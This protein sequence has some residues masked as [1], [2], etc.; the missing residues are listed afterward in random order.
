MEK[1][2]QPWDQVNVLVCFFFGF[3]FGCFIFLFFYFLFFFGGGGCSR[4]AEE[5]RTDCFTSIVVLPL[6]G[7]Q[8]SVSQPRG[9]VDW[10][11]VYDCVA[12]PDHTYIVLMCL[13]H[14]SA[15]GGWVGR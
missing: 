12:F 4:L 13:L 7:C 15:F 8:C 3:F 6:C 1:V 5:T 9:A 11:V 14:L 10:S 2:L